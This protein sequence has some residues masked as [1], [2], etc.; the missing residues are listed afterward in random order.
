MA[1]LRLGIACGGIILALLV[2]MQFLV[3]L[4]Y[5]DDTPASSFSK[6]FNQWKSR[7]NAAANND[8]FLVGAGKA[9]ITG[10]ALHWSGS[11]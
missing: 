5:G 4:Y 1:N 2:F 7:T 8:L 9:D 6:S 11:K 10:Y 3:V